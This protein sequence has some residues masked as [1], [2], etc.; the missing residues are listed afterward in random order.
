[1]EPRLDEGPP[2]VAGV[3]LD[4]IPEGAGAELDCLSEYI[5]KGVGFGP[6]GMPLVG[7][8]V[9]DRRLFPSRPTSSMP[10]V[11]ILPLRLV[12]RL[13]VA[14][15]LAALLGYAFLRVVMELQVV[16]VLGAPF[17]LQVNAQPVEE[18][19]VPSGPVP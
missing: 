13:V 14:A 19:V 18:V 15:P 11:S 6:D 16:L 8:I 12:L 5:L 17:L 3:R 4:G 10:G 7:R 1:M 2:T 9:S